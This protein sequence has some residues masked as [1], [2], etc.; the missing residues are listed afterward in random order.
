MVQHWR[1]MA[2]SGFALGNRAKGV[3][4]IAGKLLCILV[5]DV[6]VRGFVSVV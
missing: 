1:N 5:K 3:F 6:L 4:G 2:R